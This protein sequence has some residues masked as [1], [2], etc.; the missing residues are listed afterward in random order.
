MMM[1][2]E[3]MLYQL[4]DKFISSHIYSVMPE[5]R[6]VPVVQESYSK[7]I[8][9]ETPVTVQM[10]ENQLHMTDFIKSVKGKGKEK[11]PQKVDIIKQ[12]FKQTSLEKFTLPIK[13]IKIANE[14]E[15]KLKNEFDQMEWNFEGMEDEEGD[16]M[17]RNIVLKGNVEVF[18]EDMKVIKEVFDSK[19]EET[20]NC[21][22]WI[23]DLEGDLD[24]TKN[25]EEFESKL[26][27]Q[28]QMFDCN[29]K[30]TV[31]VKEWVAAG[32]QA[33]VNL[34]LDRMQETEGD[35][36]FTENQEG[37]KTK[38]ESKIVDKSLEDYEKRDKINI[39]ANEVTKA[40]KL[41][42]Y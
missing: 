34:E 33:M 29:S 19:I 4:G 10:K 14:W 35:I 8:P 9:G 36:D 28:L 23:E 16:D 6:T 26:E 39:E 37:F 42:V 31:E 22:N 32:D 30:E 40:D 41:M 1:V 11:T 24:C 17:I 15:N 38:L 21:L 18:D 20:Q 7:T 2:S 5:E 3:E 12:K 13:K 27:L 25:Q